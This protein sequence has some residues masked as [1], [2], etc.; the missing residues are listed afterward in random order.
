MSDEFAI[1]VITGNEM[2]NRDM[3]SALDFGYEQAGEFFEIASM[4]R[5]PLQILRFVIE[6]HDTPERQFAQ[7]VLEMSILDANIK[8][9]MIDL[10][11]ARSELAAHERRWCFTHTGCRE[12]VREIA[13]SR[14]RI[15]GIERQ[16]RNYT[17][18]WDAFRGWYDTHPHFT[19]EQIEAADQQYWVRRLARQCALD[20]MSSPTRDIG[21]GNRDAVRML[22]PDRGEFLLALVESLESMGF[23]DGAGD[24]LR[25]RAREAAE[26]VLAGRA[27]EMKPEDIALG[28][29]TSAPDAGLLAPLT[30]HTEVYDG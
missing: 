27:L 14:I 19:R 21:V 28:A 8:N 1:A 23:D 10:D 7:C 15:E 12:R 24:A 26:S 13:R 17:G 5:S 16:I 25:A 9:A 18:Q 6:Q 11:E 20:I 3:R 2:V 30:A 29:L 22:D 4:G